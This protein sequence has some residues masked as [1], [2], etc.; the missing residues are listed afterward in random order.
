MGNLLS[1]VKRL[2]R[3]RGTCDECGGRGKIILVDLRSAY[4]TDKADSRH[5]VAHSEAVA[6]ALPGFQRCGAALRI[7][8][9]DL[10]ES[11]L[12]RWTGQRAIRDHGAVGARS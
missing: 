12:D 9:I 7:K 2:E 11:E 10:P 4:K 1:K 3:K 5:P 8:L 6:E